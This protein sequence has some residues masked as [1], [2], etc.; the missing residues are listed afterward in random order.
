M[1]KVKLSLEKP[2]ENKS[3]SKDKEQQQKSPMISK[4]SVK[5]PSNINNNSN[6][7]I[8][9]NEN[10]EELSKTSK[11]KSKGKNELKNTSKE[12]S[13]TLYYLHN[14]KDSQPQETKD[15]R[16]F[17]LTYS[18]ASRT[19]LFALKCFK[20]KFVEYMQGKY[21]LR[22]ELSTTVLKENTILFSI[23]KDNNESFDNKFINLFCCTNIKIKH[24]HNSPPILSKKSL[25]SLKSSVNSNLSLTNINNQRSSMKNNSF[26]SLS[27]KNIRTSNPTYIKQI[28]ALS[29][30]ENSKLK[31]TINSKVSKVS[32]NPSDLDFNASSED[33]DESFDYEFSNLVLVGTSE[34]KSQLYLKSLTKISNNND[35]QS[36]IHDFENVY[37]LMNKS[38]YSSQTF[39]IRNEFNNNL[40]NSI[41]CINNGNGNGS[42]NNS[43]TA[44]ALS[45]IPNANGLSSGN[46]K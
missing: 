17:L 32:N 13:R 44:N 27:M 15:F 45:S 4:N 38:S 22:V 24:N 14:K 31:K 41:Y 20:Q 16:S 42:Q 25:M 9:I 26:E 11:S 33:L 28:K 30:Q 29:E 3:N 5:K 21:S 12:L 36:M 6:G 7:K 39:S 34:S 8:N 2:V 37:H 1:I 46:I 18:K 35:K 43:N 19:E 40:K 10:E 23:L